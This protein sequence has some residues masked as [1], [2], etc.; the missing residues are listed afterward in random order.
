MKPYALWSTKVGP[1]SKPYELAWEK[2]L[3]KINYT[4]L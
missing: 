4:N 2:W 3:F 1:D